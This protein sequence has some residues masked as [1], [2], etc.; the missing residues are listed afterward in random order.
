MTIGTLFIFREKHQILDAK[1]PYPGVI[2]GELR[3]S[4]KSIK[5][6]AWAEYPS[7]KSPPRKEHTCPLSPFDDLFA[8]LEDCAQGLDLSDFKP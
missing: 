5:I 1:A 2:L 8:V 4:I 3:S 7:D 6:P